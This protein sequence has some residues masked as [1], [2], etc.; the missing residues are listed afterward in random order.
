MPSH[1]PQLLLSKTNPT[2]LFFS[3]S[4][5]STS[6]KSFTP[7][8]LSGDSEAS[9]NNAI[10]RQELRSIGTLKIDS[11]HRTTD[12]DQGSHATSLGAKIT[13]DHERSNCGVIG[14]MI[15][16]SPPKVNFSNDEQ[17]PYTR[18]QPQPPPTSHLFCHH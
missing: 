6:S 15:F 9:T 5:W 2:T 4:I 7:N 1:P 10:Y 8:R 12:L 18:V 13:L 3:I 11:A 17:Y 16:I 14:C